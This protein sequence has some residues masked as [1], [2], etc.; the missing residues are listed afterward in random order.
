M[1]IT[2]AYP[3]AQPA[4]PDLLVAT[5]FFI[6][7]EKTILKTVSF[8]VQSLVT[9]AVTQAAEAAALLYATIGDLNLKANI[10]SP[11]FTGFIKSPS[12][13]KI[14]GLPNQFLMADGS[15]SAGG[16]YAF[17]TL[18]Q[19]LSAGPNATIGATI[20]TSGDNKVSIKGVAGVD[21]EPT[22]SIAILGQ[23]TGYGVAIKGTSQGTAIVG[24]SAEGYGLYG[25]GYGAGVY[26]QGGTYG[27]HGQSS[28]TG[29][30]G[31]GS[32][33]VQ[34]DSDYVS[35]YTFL[36]PNSVGLLIN[37]ITSTNPNADAIQVITDDDYVMR[38]NR[39]GDIYANSFIKKNG[40]AD[41][42]LMANGTV[43]F[44]PTLQQVTNLNATT[45]KA[46]TAPSFKH[47]NGL[48]TQ[49][50]MA[51][52]STST[53]AAINNADYVR[54]TTDIYTPTPKI[55][56]IVTLSASQYASATKLDSTLYIII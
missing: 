11:T 43:S 34:A 30:Y 7:G 22:N 54:N 21:N 35:F 19:V 6:V 52:G 33:G 20:T 18:Q 5:K 51:N 23:N 17:P 1:A 56:Q 9:L 41:E 36:Q 2:Y 25:T 32:I 48:A 4:S 39:Q 10:A 26:G 12:F 40:S 45:T 29:V 15:V 13:E 42:F 3:I 37:T 16:G 38:V 27:V 50:L 44:M 49:Y 8:T 14:G 28:M 46:I 53:G 47:P 24:E 31:S 55:D